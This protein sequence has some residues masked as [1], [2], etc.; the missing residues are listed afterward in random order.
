M[1]LIQIPATMTVIDPS[2]G[3]AEDKPMNWGMLPAAPGKCQECAADHTPEQPHNAQSLFYQYKFYGERGRW[4]TWKDAVA[5]CAPEIAAAWEAE[6]RKGGHWT[7]PK[8]GE[9]KK[10]PETPIPANAKFTIGDKVEGEQ[11]GKVWKPGGVIVAVVPKGV[12]PEFA[13]ADQNND[14][15]PTTYTMNSKRKT[16]YVVNFPPEA[17]DYWLGEKHVRKAEPTP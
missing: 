7:E 16:T 3:R 15:R 11:E 4:P 6:L 13:R 2:T 12:P 8:P 1:K 14:D 17:V 10:K 5:H 9:I